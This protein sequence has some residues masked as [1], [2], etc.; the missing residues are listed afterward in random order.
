[1]NMRSADLN[2]SFYQDVVQ[3]AQHANYYLECTIL[4]YQLFAQ[5]T[6]WKI[7]PFTETLQ[8]DTYRQELFERLKAK[9][10][11]GPSLG[12]AHLDPLYQYYENVKNDL[13]A[14]EGASGHNISK[15]LE[16]TRS[17]FGFVLHDKAAQRLVITFRG[18]RSGDPG[19]GL[20]QGGLY[21][22]GNADWVSDADSRAG[23]TEPRIS[24]EGN[25]ARGS[26]YV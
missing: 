18:S 14:F 16:G 13:Y 6:L 2:N 26:S 8:N 12:A 20:K 24:S 10:M 5:T 4:A 19:R 22:S 7:D 21:G 11:S 9:P 23:I 1:M 17:L 3:T 25:C 15:G